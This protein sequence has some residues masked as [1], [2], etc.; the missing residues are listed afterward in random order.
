MELRTVQT[1]HSPPDSHHA[2]ANI[3]MYYTPPVKI[4]LFYFEYIIFRTDWGIWIWAA[5]E[6]CVTKES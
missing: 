4:A 2:E 1:R 5:E 3:F 6:M